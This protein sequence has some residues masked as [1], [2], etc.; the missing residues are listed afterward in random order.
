TLGF[1]GDLLRFGLGEILAATGANNPSGAR[2]GGLAFV[3]PDANLRSPYSQHW[4]LSFEHQFARDYVVTASYVGSTGTKLIRF[5]NPN[6]GPN[7]FTIIAPDSSLPAA[8]GPVSIAP[9]RKDPNLGPFTVI[10]ASA[11]SIY[12][13]LQLSVNR[14]LANGLQFGSSYTYGH[15]IDEV[16]DVFDTAGSFT[17]PQNE[18]NL[19]A[20][21]ASAS[22]DIRHRS[23]TYFNYD[24]PFFKKYPLLSDFQINGVA[25]LQTGQ[26]FTVNQGFDIN[27]DGNLNDRLDIDGF[28]NQVDNGIQ[29]LNNPS[30]SLRDALL[31]IGTG[32]RTGGVGRNTFRA[33]GVATVD[34]AVVKKFKFNEKQF[35]S[36]RT[37]FFNLF[38]RTHFG[39]PVRTFGAPA[40]GRSVNTSL[41]ARVIQFAVKYQF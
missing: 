2:G 14:R 35:L 18:N 12:H 22:F 26:P 25:T 8:F 4:N 37:E 1:R 29:R 13:S 10:E 15:T 21:R 17:L 3:L 23:V 40:F 30:K 5:R 41:S 38:N 34:L 24:L 16:S 39:I 36:V 31:L 9:P 11:S 28:I 32:V 19:R 27:R 7:S 20:E 33:A 6:G